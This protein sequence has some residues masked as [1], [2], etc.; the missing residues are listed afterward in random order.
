VWPMWPNLGVGVVGQCRRRRRGKIC[1]CILCCLL[2]VIGGSCC[3]NLVAWWRDWSGLHD[4]HGRL[5]VLEVGRTCR[6]WNWL[7]IVALVRILGS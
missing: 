6:L 1:A 3:R 5:L 2:C 4:N 7:A